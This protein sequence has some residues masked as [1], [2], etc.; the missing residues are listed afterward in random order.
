MSNFEVSKEDKAAVSHIKAIQD[1][2]S[3]L[4]QVTNHTGFCLSEAGMLIEYHVNKD[5]WEIL[6]VRENIPDDF[7]LLMKALRIEEHFTL[8]QKLVQLSNNEFQR[9][10]GNKVMQRISRD[11]LVNF[12]EGNQDLAE[13]LP[14]P[15]LISAA[16]SGEQLHRLMF[17]NFFFLQDLAAVIDNIRHNEVFKSKFT[18]G[19]LKTISNHV[20]NISSV[21]SIFSMGV[22][23]FYEQND[24]IKAHQKFVLG[25]H[26]LLDYLRSMVL[27]LSSNFQSPFLDNTS[28]ANVIKRST[29]TFVDGLEIAV[30]LDAGIAENSLPAELAE[31]IHQIVFNLVVNAWKYSMHSGARSY[32]GTVP[33]PV[34]V[35]I[36]LN[37]DNNVVIVISDSGITI[38]EEAKPRVLAGEQ[39]HLNKPELS[40]IPTKGQGIK[41]IQSILSKYP[42]AFLDI[43]NNVGDGY[44]KAFVATIPYELH[45]ELIEQ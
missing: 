6:R 5:K 26:G 7:D 16:N 20:H 19:Q 1:E 40:S 3:P 31:D 41:L 23:F 11:T 33:E 35:G 9:Q 17:E 13:F 27:T 14:D 29:Q 39:V 18:S 34:K 32:L 24:S 12:I 37:E 43:I 15:N 28:F 42:G 45:P 44:E 8:I 21:I 25:V 2:L 4:S 30:G 36:S 10:R 22:Y 38:S